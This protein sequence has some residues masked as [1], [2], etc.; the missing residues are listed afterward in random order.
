MPFLSDN[1]ILKYKM[2]SVIRFIGT[3]SKPTLTQLIYIG[4]TP[5]DLYC[6]CAFSSWF[7][8]FNYCSKE[9]IP[10]MFGKFW[11]SCLFI[12]FILMFETMYLNYGQKR[13]YCSSLKLYEYIEQWWNYIY[14]VKLKNS[15]KPVSQYLLST[16][17]STYIDPG[18]NRRLRCER[19]ETNYVRYDTRSLI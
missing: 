9:L 7:F 14:R 2:P 8:M 12:F 16:T 1:E 13:A 11:F 5:H 10:I 6:L 4:D 15:E 3:D 19:P 17:D 18:A